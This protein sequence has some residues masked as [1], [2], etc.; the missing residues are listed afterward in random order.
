MKPQIIL[1]L[2]KELNAEF[3]EVETIEII[4]W[5]LIKGDSYAYSTD[6]KGNVIGLRI[7]N[8]I[9]NYPTIISICKKLEV[10]NLSKNQIS[11]ITE[12][13]KL[14]SLKKLHLNINK[15]TNIHPLE[16]LNNLTELYLAE[17]EISDISIIANLRKLQA[18][19]IPRNQIKDISALHKLINLTLLVLNSNQ[20]KNIS[21]I[22]QLKKLNLLDLSTNPINELPDWICKFPKMN[23]KWHYNW[24]LGYINFED[25]PIEN[26]PIEIIKQGKEAIKNYFEELEKG[27]VNLYETKLLLVGYGAV[28]K[29]SLMKR[30]VYDEYNENEVSTEGIDIKRWDL[31]TKIDKELKINIWDFGGQ[32]IYH[33][34]HQFFLSKRSIYLLVWDARI[35]RMMPNL[36]SFDYWLHIVSLLSKNSPII[37]VQNKIDQRT[38][39]VDEKYMKDYFPNIVGFYKVSAK[40][41]TGISELK[42]IIQNEI[43]QLPHIG[44]QL[45]KVW[46]DIR[47]NFK[48]KQQNYIKLD[49]YLSVC[50]LYDIDYEQAIHL[51][52]YFHDLG[53]FLH[54]Q[55][56]DI[57]R[58]IIFLNPEWATKAVYKVIDT[59]EI[60]DN[61]G[62][63]NYSQLKDIWK[64]YPDDKFSF[65]I[66]LMK[67]FE[68]CFQLPNKVDYIVPELLPPTQPDDIT[69]NNTENFQFEYRY[70]FVPAGV[71]TRL[72]VRMHNIIKDNIFWLHGLVVK[73]ED[74]EA[75]IT[76]NKFERYIRVKVKGK[77]KQ[78]LFGIIRYEIN[79]IHKTLKN[80][81]VELMTHCICDECNTS[82]RPEFY[83]FKQLNKYL[84]KGKNTITCPKSVSEV[85]I[86]KLLGRVNGEGNKKSF[87]EYLLVAL[88][89]LQGLSLSIQKYEDSRNSFVATMLTNKNYRVK[90]QTKWGIAKTQ[91]GEIDIKIEDEEGGAFA[92]CEAFN[93]HNFDKSKIKN[94]INKIFNYD[95]NGLP[96]N[97]I[98]VY[99]DINFIQNWQKYQ[100]LLQ[101][102]DYEHEFI[103]FTDISNNSDINTDIKVGIARHKRNDKTI[104]IYHIFVKL[105]AIT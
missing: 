47:D 62:K 97:Y 57:L 91:P 28:G 86:N 96:E 34:T 25:N 104:K 102:I 17:N 51:S 5:F 46:I 95:A 49:K 44:E 61:G 98:I 94:H 65:L 85:S 87:F 72:I 8:N 82:E 38:S 100:T 79:N 31:K 77:N 90:D 37:I 101:T 89:Q 3:K 7:N 16:G 75:I 32:E 84:D 88:K 68:L 63:F 81:P 33:S 22:Q 74:T 21:P 2:E 4:Q 29:T 56:N 52:N 26:L 41:K 6:K 83:A 80:P 92:I 23:I 10:L 59:K 58:N 9:K 1:Q 36:A 73:Q 55:D 64:D 18:L 27:T 24:E 60:V 35:D 13:Q 45:P 39:L 20:I 11:D 78:D 105:I 50:S 15:I 99:S 43:Q 69:W 48:N 54:F 42:S 76:I 14:Q 71:I 66:E 70:K 103:D 67:K 93:L 40:D 30:L 12:I 19:Y 53:I